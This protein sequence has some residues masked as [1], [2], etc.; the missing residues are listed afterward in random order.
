MPVSILEV[1]RYLETMQPRLRRHEIVEEFLDLV[2]NVPLV[3]AQA[4]PLQRM[5]VQ[6][7]VGLLPPWA[8]ELLE[9][10]KGHLLRRAVR[11]LIRATVAFSGHL[12]R[13]G[14]PQQACLR[15]GRPPSSL[16]R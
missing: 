11:P 6:A 16:C 3:A 4:L 7:A 15:M 10:E 13:N 1:E 12:I 14:P 5:L 8:R 9:L 2:W